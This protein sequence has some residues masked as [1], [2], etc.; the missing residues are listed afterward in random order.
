MVVTTTTTTTDYN[1][2]I[3]MG[4]FH[5]GLPMS[6]GDTLTMKLTM[7]VMMMAF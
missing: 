2:Y 5:S 7:L 4:N 1:N 6:S 3:L